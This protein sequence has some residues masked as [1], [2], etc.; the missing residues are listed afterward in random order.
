MTIWI[1][2]VKLKV[3]T[4][5]ILVQ[6]DALDGGLAVDALHYIHGVHAHGVFENLSLSRFKKQ[7]RVYNLH[8]QHFFSLAA[9]FTQPK[10]LLVEP[11]FSSLTNLS[12]QIIRQ[13]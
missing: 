5:V 4:E 2:M 6:I 10:Q 7:F 8:F 3:L 9:V 12:V 1:K 13:T 11:S